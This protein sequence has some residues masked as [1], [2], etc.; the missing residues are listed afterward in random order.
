MKQIVDRSYKPAEVARILSDQYAHKVTA[1]VIR[2]WDATLLSLIKDG[3]ERSKGENRGYS[4]KDIQF[5]NL[6]AV[7]RNLG[8]SLDRIK[9]LFENLDPRGRQ[10]DHDIRGSVGNR[11][12]RQRE[13]FTQVEHFLA[14][15]MRHSNKDTR[16]RQAD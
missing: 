2:K 9:D 5:F 15:L 8:Y 7:L 12:A 6:I 13:A 1:A 11:I 10:K 4:E 16:A 3:S 14:S